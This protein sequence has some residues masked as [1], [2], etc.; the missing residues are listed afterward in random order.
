[1]NENIE[2]PYDSKDHPWIEMLSDDSVADTQYFYHIV[3]YPQ[4]S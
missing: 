3:S 4:L 1:M 2:A